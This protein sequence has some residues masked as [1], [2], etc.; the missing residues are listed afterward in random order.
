MLELVRLRALA[1]VPFEARDVAD[2]QYFVV[3]LGASDHLAERRV[4]RRLRLEYHLVR[5]GR[6]P[7][8][9]APALRRQRG[10]ATA[11]D[12]ACH[13]N[14]AVRRSEPKGPGA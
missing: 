9:A 12:A 11:A 14:A 13:A 4:R 6:F 10:V 5:D 3:A 7:A 1:E 8:L 2:E